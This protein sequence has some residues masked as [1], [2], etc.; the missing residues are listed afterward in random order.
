MTRATVLVV[1]DE[2]TVRDV[3]ARYLRHEG[4]EALEA[5]DGIEALGMAAD[6]DLVVLDLMLPGL[7]GIEVCRRLRE[8][9]PVPVI[10]LTAKGEETE[11][12]VGL[13]VGADDYVVKPF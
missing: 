1:D 13:G 4:Y 6:A 5:R 9:R 7:D 11:K 12:L 8:E 10:M 3:V 2:T